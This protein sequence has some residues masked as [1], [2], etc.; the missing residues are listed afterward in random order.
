MYFVIGTQLAVSI[1]AGLILGQYV[2]KW[3]GTKT[4]VYTI[5]G[6]IAGV[7]SGFSLLIRIIKRKNDNESN[8]AGKNADTK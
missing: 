7:I 3:A 6:L 5:I 2:D 1:L 4:P 8:E